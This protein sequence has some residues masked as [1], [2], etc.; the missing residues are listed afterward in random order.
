MMKAS[1]D[2]ILGSGAS[3]G[4]LMNAMKNAAMVVTKPVKTTGSRPYF[5]SLCPRIPKHKPPMISPT[6]TKIPCR[7][8]KCKTPKLILWILKYHNNRALIDYSLAI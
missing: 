2:V 5:T 4:K 3:P 6:P 7:P 1:L 8:K